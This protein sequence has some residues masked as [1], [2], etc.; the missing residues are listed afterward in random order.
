MAHARVVIFN[1]RPG[2]ARDVA[3]KAEREVLPM[4]RSQPGFISYTLATQGEDAVL[5]FS[6]WDSKRQAEEANRVAGEWVQANL[7]GV[8]VS[9]DRHIGDVAFSF[10][11]AQVHVAGD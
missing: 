9:V 8:L 7:R 2:S 4:F 6:M 5:S 11:S 3:E 1:L 10:P